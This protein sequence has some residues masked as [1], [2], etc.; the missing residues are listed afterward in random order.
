MA[1]PKESGQASNVIDE[2]PNRNQRVLGYEYFD[3]TDIT[4]NKTVIRSFDKLLICLWGGI[5]L[6]VDPYSSKNSGTVELFA[7]A[8]ADAA[9]E[10]PS[11]FVIGDNGTT[12]A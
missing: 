6:V 5:D 11:A 12:H 3:H 1:T 4:A 7:N 9:L 2:N 8:F 10:Q